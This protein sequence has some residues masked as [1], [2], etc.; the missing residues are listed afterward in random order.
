MAPSALCC[1]APAPTAPSLPLGPVAHPFAGGCSGLACLGAALPD[2]GSPGAASPQPVAR[3]LHWPPLSAAYW[4]PALPS[5]APQ[6]SNYRS[7]PIP[8]GDR[9][10]NASIDSGG[11][12]RA[13]AEL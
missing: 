6:E 8:K 5:P 4:L 9:L 2:P 10:E 12:S 7:R 13:P 3:L 11:T 1:V